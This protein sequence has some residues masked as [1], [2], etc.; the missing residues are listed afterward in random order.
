MSQQ[1][2]RDFMKGRIS[3]K[4][5]SMLL[6]AIGLLVSNMARAQQLVPML[7][8]QTMED[9]TQVYVKKMVEFSGG[10]TDAM[11]N[12]QSVTDDDLQNYLNRLSSTR[13]ATN[14]TVIDLSKF[15][16]TT[17]ETTLLIS[18][19]ISVK[20]ING[21]L[22]RGKGLPESDPIVRIS[23]GAEVDLDPSV[24]IS[25]E[26]LSTNG[27][28]AV[29]VEDASLNTAARIVNLRQ[30]DSFYM[31]YGINAKDK[32]SNL[33]VYGSGGSR[34][35]ILY[36]GD[37]TVELSSCE[38]VFY[39]ESKGAVNFDGETVKLTYWPMEYWFHETKVITKSAISSFTLQFLTLENVNNLGDGVALLYGSD[40]YQLTQ[41]DLDKIDIQL[42]SLS[43][44]N[45]SDYEKRLEGN[46][47]VLRKKGGPDLQHDIDNAPDDIETTIDLDNYGALTTG[48][49]ISGKK[50]IRMTGTKKI[51]LADN[52]SGEY[53]FRTKDGAQLDITIPG[54]DWNEGTNIPLN[55]FIAGYWNSTIEIGMYDDSSIYYPGNLMYTEKGGTIYCKALINTSFYNSA[56]GT[57]YLIDGGGEIKAPTAENLSD[58][59]ITGN[60]A[61]YGTFTALGK[62][63]VGSYSLKSLSELILGYNSELTIEYGWSADSSLTISFLNDR[64]EL[65]R[66][67]IVFDNQTNWLSGF[68][69]MS[70]KLKDG[71]SA[72]FDDDKHCISIE[73]V[74]EDALS[75]FE[76]QL[77]YLFEFF[78]V[79]MEKLC[80]LEAM[81]EE[82]YAQGQLSK[83]EYY[84]MHDICKTLQ[85]D[86]EI[87]RF[88]LSAIYGLR[89]VFYGVKSTE[90]YRLEVNDVKVELDLLNK[91][92][93]E[94][95]DE[96]EKRSRVPYEPSSTDDLQDYLNQLKES[97]ETTPDNPGVIVIPG[98]MVIDDIV[99]PE[100]TN[101]EIDV[102][103][104]LQAYLD[105]LV[106]VGLGASL[107]LNGNYVVRGESTNASIYVR[108]T[109]DIY[110]TI[111]LEGTKT[112][113]IHVYEGG[114]VNWRGN[115]T[116]GKIVNKGIFNLYTGTADYLEN[117]GTLQHHAGICHHIV[118]HETYYL[119]GGYINTANTDHRYAL[120]N[121]GKAYLTGGTIISYTTLIINYV[122]SVTYIDG[123]KLDDSNATTTIISYSDFHIR[124]DYS[125]KH[126][127]LDNGVRINFITVWTVRWHITF[128]DNRTTIRKVIFHS[129]EFDVN[130]D[131]I[132]FIDFDLP[133]GYRWYYNTKENGLEIRDTKVHDSDDLQAFLDRLAMTPGSES[134][135]V[136]LDGDN[137]TVDL[138]MDTNGQF[139][140]PANTY[141]EIRNIIFRFISTTSQ[142]IW[143]IP[144]GSTVILNN[145]TI[146]GGDDEYGNDNAELNVSGGHLYINKVV[147]INIHLTLNCTIYICGPLSSNIYLSYLN[148]GE[149]VD[150]ALVAEGC[151][152]YRLT[153]A[154][155]DKFIHYN[156]VLG[157][158]WNFI[159]VDNTI[160]LH[161]EY[162][163]VEALPGNNSPRVYVDGAGKLNISGVP[164]DTQCFI[165]SSDG[166]LLKRGTV[167]EITASGTMLARGCYV[168]KVGKTTMK[169]AR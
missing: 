136:I 100:N 5:T 115:M 106:T 26:N 61:L 105:G 112:E 81:T 78:E 72:Y 131:Y 84:D 159:L 102:K 156:D 1:E 49:L 86:A 76:N 94:A 129:D 95:Y 87:S 41:N 93:D 127:V 50:K 15:S 53:I 37:N 119:K 120:E 7:E 152:G 147:F 150:G 43:S 27:H 29:V 126:I 32:A 141:V 21:Q 46:S 55:A 45:L 54:F 158:S 142:K 108:G 13:S 60:Y 65:D 90:K 33:K 51:A 149:I 36:Y 99:I 38:V 11:R 162:T 40:D 42:S 67:Y 4:M 123:V 166:V 164:D 138:K 113:V 48:I 66:P 167:S 121:Y 30:G 71:H 12:A 52:F 19:G 74:D 47:V 125:P 109:I 124:G 91:K 132:R 24:T 165:Y 163:G 110:A 114:T 103:D 39:H 75:S 146:D 101:V 155:L 135:P 98:N 23:G 3:F 70:F 44:L 62:A 59:R 17:R 9:G 20:F 22:T 82:N 153:Q 31:A 148:N 79:A 133:D 161:K 118:N 68:R 69:N 2:Q 6:V 35:D 18:G 143:Y 63:S 116:S 80:V 56:G 169:F 73:E 151:M 134:S 157:T 137:H 77:D 85:N 28:A 14:Q 97:G 25:G 83:A 144:S 140:F 128:I 10:T 64:Y 139:E 92:I 34:L 111:I 160:Q 58:T 145:V 96:L 130:L 154:D 107:K 16:A 117:H 88:K 89:H 122:N 57:I 104:D 8:L 168:L